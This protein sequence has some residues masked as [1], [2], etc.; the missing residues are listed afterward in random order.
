M[1]RSFELPT[2]FGTVFFNVNGANE[3]Y[4]SSR[5][6][7]TAYGQDVYA[8][9]VIRNKK[10]KNLHLRFGLHPDGTLDGLTYDSDG[11]TIV[12]VKDKGSEYYEQ[13]A[14]SLNE[15]NGGLSF[16]ESTHAAKIALYREIKEKLNK[17]YS[18]NPDSIN[19]EFRARAL[20]NKQGKIKELQEKI[21]ELKQTLFETEK[22]L[23]L[24]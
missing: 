17:F 19:H 4:V 18:E 15:G 23:S 9:I 3:I 11:N 2:K 5:E 21:A 24:I 6:P 12:F 22:E 16:N 14:I 1:N 7:F 8:D 20:E 10:H 13:R